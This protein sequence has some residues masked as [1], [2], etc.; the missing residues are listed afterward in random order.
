MNP[1]VIIED[2]K[3]D[4]EIIKSV[5]LGLEFEKELIFF[6]SAE[7]AFQY[8]SRP[9][10]T[11]FIIFSDINLPGMNG[12]QLRD[13]IHADPV[14]R[15]KCIPYLFLT[16]GGDSNVVW[17]AYSKIAQGFFIKPNTFKAWEILMKSIVFYW[18]QSKK[19]MVRGKVPAEDLH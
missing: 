11:P 4:Q 17:E 16:T 8:L 7:L 3:D 5:L 2:D 6:P 15:I 13:K 12:F 9:D 19:P 18:Q 10:I 14:L 1:I